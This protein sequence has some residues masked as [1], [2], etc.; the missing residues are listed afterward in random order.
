MP[1]HYTVLS[2]NS[3]F[4]IFTLIIQTCRSKKCKN[5]SFC[6]KLFE[7]GLIVKKEK[8]IQVSFFLY[9]KIIHL[10]EYLSDVVWRWIL[11]KKRVE[12]MWTNH[13]GFVSY[14]PNARPSYWLNP[15][16]FTLRYQTITTNHHYMMNQTAQMIHIWY[17]RVI[18]ARFIAIA[19]FI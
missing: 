12:I 19:V 11:N 17:L 15:V 4:F 13:Q 2:K 3:T 10:F 5:L 14:W 18:F 6:R 16:L 8:I 7:T 1:V 9:S